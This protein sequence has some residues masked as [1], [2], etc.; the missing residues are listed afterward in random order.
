MVE[1]VFPKPGTIHKDTLLQNILWKNTLWKSKY[2]S[3]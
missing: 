1:D 3:C 2:D